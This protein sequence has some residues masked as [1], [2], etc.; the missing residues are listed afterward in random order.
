MICK[1]A[2]VSRAKLPEGL[3]RAVTCLRESPEIH[4]LHR[5]HADSNSLY[6]A[7]VV[8]FSTETSISTNPLQIRNSYETMQNVEYG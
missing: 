6:G 8:P 3:S 4:Y 1:N 5:W 2:T 7:I